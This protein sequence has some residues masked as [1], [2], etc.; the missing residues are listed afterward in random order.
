MKPATWRAAVTRH[1][2]PALPGDWTVSRD[3][4]VA[5]QGHYSR[6]VDMAQS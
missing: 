1:L 4:T 6:F 5:F 3:L 2:L